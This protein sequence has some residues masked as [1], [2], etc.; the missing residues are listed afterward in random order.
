[1]TCMQFSECVS[2]GGCR[3]SVFVGASL[4]LT[5]VTLS[6]ALLRMLRWV[7]VLADC[8]DAESRCLRD[9][10]RWFYTRFMKDFVRVDTGVLEL[11]FSGICDDAAQ[12]DS[13]ANNTTSSSFALTRFTSEVSAS[14]IPLQNCLIPCC[15]N[16]M[17]CTGWCTH[18]PAL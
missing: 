11:Q 4:L 15:L 12:A 18:I 1:M 7:H 6:A 2:G 14:D 17:H 3:Y 13:T 10:Q 8:T 9:V 16:V 5:F